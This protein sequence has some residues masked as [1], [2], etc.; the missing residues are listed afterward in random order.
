M[1]WRAE[2]LHA[3]EAGEGAQADLGHVVADAVVRAHLAT[4]LR[5]GIRYDVLPRESEILHLQ[6][7]GYRL[8][9]FEGTES[10]LLRD[11]RQEQRC[12]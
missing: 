5:L 1:K 2:T 10:N 11:G 4:M 3:I 8:R 12:G 6:F 9:A 7:W